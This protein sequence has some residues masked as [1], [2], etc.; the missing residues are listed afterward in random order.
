MLISDG[1]FSNDYSLEDEQRLSSLY[2]KFIFAFYKRETQYDVTHPQIP[3]KVDNGIYDALPIMQTDIMVQN[4]N[5]TLIIDTKFYSENMAK[6]FEGG[7]AKQKSAN[8]YQIF[9]YVNNWQAKFD[10]TVSGM[11][12]Y[13]KTHSEEQP[14]HHYEIN[15]N[16][17]SI[18][19]IDLN[20]DFEEIKKNLL[21]LVAKFLK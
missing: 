16:N 20:C 8:L 5:K 15:G 10:E 2:E 14:N 1:D 11:L 9:A 18:I 6:R 17:I 7:V 12:L 4:Q 21:T 19:T 13:A 3:W